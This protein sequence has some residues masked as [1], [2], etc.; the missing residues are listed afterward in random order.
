[1]GMSGAL[2][3][4]GRLSLTMPIAASFWK[5]T[6]PRSVMAA[7]D[8]GDTVQ[9]QADGPFAEKGGRHGFQGGRHGQRNFRLAKNVAFEVDARRNLGDHQAVR[10]QLHHATLGHI[11]NVL[12]LGHGAAAGESDVLDFSY[13][14]LDLS[15]PI[16]AH[17][18]V[19]NRQLGTGVEEAGKD[20]LPGA[21]G[22]VHEPSAAG[23]Y[24]WPHGKP[25]DVY[26]TVAVDLQE[27]KQRGIEAT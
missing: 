23:R 2:T 9:L 12:A 5:V 19:G 21:R 16:D 24:M 18:A 4:S 25:R 8:G 13:H 7:S 3:F 11:G 14:L 20:Y 15:F 22:D 10:R 27:R 17:G 6:R 26:R 1:M